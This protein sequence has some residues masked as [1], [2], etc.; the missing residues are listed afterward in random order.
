[1]KIIN[2]SQGYIVQ[3]D[4]IDYNYLIQWDWYILKNKWNNCYARRTIWINNKSITILMHH[5]IIKRM[6]LIIFKDYEVDHKDRDGLHN[7]RDNLHIVTS[8]L[9]QHNRL[10]QSNNTSGNKGIYKISENRYRAMGFIDG[11]RIHLGYFSSKIEA[12]NVRRNWEKSH[13]IK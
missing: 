6:G 4:D 5:E 13:K 8:S 3:V 7:W 2:I 10:L 9:N 12:I 11:N 1:M